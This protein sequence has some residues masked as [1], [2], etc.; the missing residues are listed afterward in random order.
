MDCFYSTTKQLILSCQFENWRLKTSSI[1]FIKVQSILSAKKMATTKDSSWFLPWSPTSKTSS[2]KRALNISSLT[3]KIMW[4]LNLE[5][6]SSTIKLTRGKVNFRRRVL[7]LTSSRRG[8]SS[9][10]KINCSI[11]RT[12]N[13]RTKTSI[14]LCW[15]TRKFRLLAAPST[16]HRST[17]SK[18]RTKT[19]SMCWALNLNMIWTNGCTQF[20]VKFSWLRTTAI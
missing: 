1:R 20:R 10:T 4:Y 6:L 3:K 15:G 9:L 17:A 8:S 12:R 19:G 2:N 13:R 14:L 5:N 18:L 7:T 11:I 16:S